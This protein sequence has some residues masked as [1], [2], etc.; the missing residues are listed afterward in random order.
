MTARADS[1]ERRHLSTSPP[2]CRVRGTLKQAGALAALLAFAPLPALGDCAPPPPAIT[3]LD[4]TRFYADAKGSLVD[5]DK[6]ARHKAETAPLAVFL[7]HVTSEADKALRRSKTADAAVAAQ[8]ALRWLAAWAKAGALLGTMGSQQAEAERKWDFT[9]SALAYLKLKRFATVEQTAA[10]EPWLIQLADVSRD[11]FNDAGHKRNNHWYWLGLGLGATGLATGS[12][13][14]WKEARS[15]MHDAAR[16][17]AADGTLPLE[18]A[19]GTRAL[20]YHVFAAM[21]LV[22]LAELGRARGEDFYALGGGALDRLVDVTVR[23][24][25]APE[26]FD[27]LAGEAQ[28]RPVA[29][30]AGWLPLY[31]STHQRAWA[32]Q[33]ALKTGHRWLGGDV[34]L[35][36][37]VLKAR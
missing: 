29:L 8:C 35:L 26:L 16:D 25:V 21:P 10:I 18:L 4:L 9:G 7:R 34:L 30:G 13:R 6:A 19:R 31:Q 22:T 2:D 27:K 23:G 28:E 5:P 3:S 1:R 20:H 24:L 36:Q 11:F 32:G 37:A 14:H 33:P 12:E 17:I 15:I